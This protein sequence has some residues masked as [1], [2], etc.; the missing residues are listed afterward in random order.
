MLALL[1]TLLLQPP[2]V[3]LHATLTV[4]GG[5][6]VTWQQPADAQGLTC[7]YHKRGASPAVLF[8]CWTLPAGDIRVLIGP[9]FDAAQRPVLGESVYLLVQD[10]QIVSRASVRA[11]VWLPVVRG[12]P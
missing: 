4:D 12:S 7:L 10:N 5:A 2:P 11:P 6:Q 8:D 1:L 3:D 9:P